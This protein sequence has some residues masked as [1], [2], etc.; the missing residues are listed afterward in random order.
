MSIDSELTEVTEEVADVDHSALNNDTNEA[1]SSHAEAS[2]EMEYVRETAR[3]EIEDKNTDDK[4]ILNKDAVGPHM[5]MAICGVSSG[6]RIDTD[7]AD[8][9][10]CEEWV[11]SA[12]ERL[13][14]MTKYLDNINNV[15]FNSSAEPTFCR[16][17]K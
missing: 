13:Q 11:P 14:N 17:R 12:I 1:E 8:G 5:S 9:N 2:N 15:R 10:S 16:V 6:K 7:Q 3:V 4:L